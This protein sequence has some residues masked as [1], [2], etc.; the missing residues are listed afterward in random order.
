MEAAL[1]IG[2]D[3][4]ALVIE[5]VEFGLAV[6]E[7][8]NGV[9]TDQVLCIAFLGQIDPLFL[10]AE[11]VIK[12]ATV[13]GGRNFVGAG[14][15]AALKGSDALANGADLIFPR[16]VMRAV[17]QPFAGGVL[18][19]GVEIDPVSLQGFDLGD[20]VAAAP[21]SAISLRNSSF[22]PRSESRSWLTLEM[23]LVTVESGRAAPGL[24][25]W[26]EER[27]FPSCS[28]S[29]MRCWAAPALS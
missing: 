6:G 12:E 25:V 14:L 7:I 27:P 24:N 26:M 28:N 11:F 15:D 8:A 4:S 1:G 22:M 23:S 20:P 19:G 16:D 29:E 21:G 3:F 18:E 9:C 13:V 2:K 17:L 10:A 5:P